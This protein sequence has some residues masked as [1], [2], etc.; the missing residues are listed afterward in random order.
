MS[1]KGTFESLIRDKLSVVFLAFY[2]LYSVLFEVETFNE[3]L[4]LLGL[5]VLIIGII[6]EN[7]RHVEKMGNTEKSK[8]LIVEFKDHLNKELQR[9]ETI[10]EEDD[11]PVK[12][13]ADYIVS[14][15][16]SPTVTDVT[17]PVEEEK[18][19]EKVEVV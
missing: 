9:F 18:P 14:L 8:D 15:L 7:H 17:E 5:V 1:V 19:V 4:R 16:T 2:L 12:T 11:D 13:L 10:V 3:I 6:Y